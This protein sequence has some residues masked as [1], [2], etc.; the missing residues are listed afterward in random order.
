MLAC[1]TPRAALPVSAGAVL[2]RL[3]RRAARSVCRGRLVTAVALAD[4][5]SPGRA[6]CSAWLASPPP[7]PA[8]EQLLALLDSGAT[9]SLYRAAAQAHLASLA[10]GASSTAGLSERLAPP[11]SPPAAELSARIAAV[12]ASDARFLE[13]CALLS[14][15]AAAS[16]AAAGISLHAELP[17]P[18][19]APLRLGVTEDALEA[20]LG[21]PD[22]AQAARELRAHAGTVLPPGAD[23]TVVV[24]LDAPSGARLYAGSVLFG[25][26]VDGVMAAMRG[27]DESG[28]PTTPDAAVISAL[29]RSTRSEEA[30]AATQRRA[31]ALWGL[32]PD[33]DGGYSSALAEFSTGVTIAPT[34]AVS[35]FYDTTG[36][37]L[38]GA[39]SAEEATPGATELPSAGGLLPLRAG[40]LRD[41]LLEAAAWGWH[42]AAAERA[43]AQDARTARL[44]TSR[45]MPPPQPPQQR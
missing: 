32:S 12:R 39:G 14:L 23:P 7:S 8:T 15:S 17:S 2:S 40:T 26:F 42:M 19:A 35:E 10:E 20:L 33:A 37:R 44:L 22:G 34:A 18:S 36:A 9:S 25:Y 31:G 43:M 27:V 3:S 29:A 13:V 41:L 11:G 28:S 24:R 21:Q 4:S 30:W 6:P 1:A 5:A 38:A 16:F 45:P